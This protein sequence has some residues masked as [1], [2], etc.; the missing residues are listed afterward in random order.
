MRDLAG[1]L[2]VAD[3]LT[4]AGVLP[5][6]WA[7]LAAADVALVPSRVEPFGNAAVEAM[8]A[9]RP[10][11]VGDTQG[12]REIVRHGVTGELVPPGD[13]DALAAAVRRTVEDW[14]AP[15]TRAAAARGEAAERYAPERYRR[16]SRR[17]SGRRRGRRGD[18]AEAVD[19]V[20]A[21]RPAHARR[22]LAEPFRQRSSGESRRRDEERL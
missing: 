5:A 12:L 18:R 1:Q 13:A 22:D 11:V 9:G 19:E 10:V 21:R 17:S 20:T 14:P 3:R 7:P 8:L 2:G 16:S 4:F 6:V 15:L